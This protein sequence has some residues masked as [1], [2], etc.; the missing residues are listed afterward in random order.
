MSIFKDKTPMTP[1]DMGDRLAQTALDQTE[2]YAHQARPPGS[3]HFP[4]RDVEHAMR[5]RRGHDY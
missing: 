3:I 4:Y 1:P 2:L 5:P